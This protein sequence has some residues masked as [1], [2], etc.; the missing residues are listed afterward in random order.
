VYIETNNEQKMQNVEKI[1]AQGENLTTEFK[2]AKEQLPSSLFET[3]NTQKPIPEAII[4]PSK[5]MIYFW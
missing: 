4:L 1:I 5:K 2:L 3:L